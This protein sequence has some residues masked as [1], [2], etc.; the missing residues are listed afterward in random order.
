MVSENTHDTRMN[1]NIHEVCSFVYCLVIIRRKVKFHLL[2][3]PYSHEPFSQNRFPPF[4]RYESLSFKI[5]VTTLCSV[6]WV[7]NNYSI[8]HKYQTG[9]IM[10]TILLTNRVTTV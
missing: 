4:L 6:R 1:D 7:T 5:I 9:M 3:R 8:S 2:E 10:L